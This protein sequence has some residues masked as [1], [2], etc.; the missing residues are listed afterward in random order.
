M[1]N[2]KKKVKGDECLI[3]QLFCFI[4]RKNRFLFNAHLALCNI[5]EIKLYF[6]F[7]RTRLQVTVKNLQYLVSVFPVLN[8]PLYMQ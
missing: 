4:E 5:T 6:L 3:F 7:L 2:I 1:K 8:N